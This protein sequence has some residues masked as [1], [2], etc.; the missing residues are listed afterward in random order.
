M[1][2]NEAFLRSLRLVSETVI[3]VFAS[4]VTFKV[5]FFDRLLLTAGKNGRRKFL[6]GRIKM[7]LPKEKAIQSIDFYFF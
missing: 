7:C 6:Y 2:L 4:S 3:Y 1:N 5:L